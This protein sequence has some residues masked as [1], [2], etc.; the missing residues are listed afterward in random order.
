[1]P[2]RPHRRGALLSVP[3]GARSLSA[4]PDSSTLLVG[5]A[6][7]SGGNALHVVRV[8]ANAAAS[9]AVYDIDAEVWGAAALPAASAPLAAVALRC[10]GAG[11]L[12]V[13]RLPAGEA[14]VDDEEAEPERFVPIGLAEIDVPGVVR[15]L[16]RT[17]NER[18]LLL[19]SEKDVKVVHV[20][21]GSSGVEVEATLSRSSDDAI[22]A[23]DFGLESRSVLVATRREVRLLDLRSPST[24]SAV[25]LGLPSPSGGALRLAP[26]PVRV[27]SAA[28]GGGSVLAVGDADGFVRGVDARSARGALWAASAHAH[29]VTAVGVGPRDAVA[30][31]GTDG[32]ARAWVEGGNVGTYPIHGEA[33]YAARWLGDLGFASCSFDGR[34]AVNAP[35]VL[36]E[37]G[38]GAL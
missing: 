33:V 14:D 3:R 1:M 20:D 37:E 32:V 28:C 35:A 18:T 17:D 21:A 7:A 23:V 25:S 30:S 26:R 13:W 6:V 11:K 24:G 10:R 27:V 16:V 29:W 2:P 36:G 19:H 38:M 4:S 34:L 5:T 31:G 15:G 8:G 22:V 9:S 12:A